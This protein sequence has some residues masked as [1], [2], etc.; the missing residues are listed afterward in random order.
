ML[1]KSLVTFT[2]KTMAGMFST[3]TEPYG[4]IL[5]SPST[6][7]C[8]VPEILV[9]PLLR[10]REILEILEKQRRLRVSSKTEGSPSI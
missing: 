10:R 3:R 6:Q 8:A 4:G 1:T 2:L 7:I 9:T 5:E